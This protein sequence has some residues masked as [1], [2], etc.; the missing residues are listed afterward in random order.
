M[1]LRDGEAR[2]ESFW[3][4]HELRAWSTFH[5]Q[6]SSFAWDNTCSGRRL[7]DMRTFGLSMLSAEWLQ[8][9]RRANACKVAKVLLL[10]RRLVHG[11]A[12]PASSCQ[13]LEN[14]TEGSEFFQQGHVESV[15]SFMAHSAWRF[16]GTCGVGRD[17]CVGLAFCLG[18]GGC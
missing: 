14:F 15:V 3:S 17:V 10:F 12:I 1:N 18:L 16:G 4:R 7:T 8:A 9:V 5:C 11:L 6:V 13:G 2:A